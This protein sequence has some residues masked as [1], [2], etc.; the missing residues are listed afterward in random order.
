MPRK[1]SIPSASAP[2]ECPYCEAPAATERLLALHL[3]LQHYERLDEAERDAY[4]AAYRE[5]Q[6][7][8]RRFRLG[9]LGGLVLLYFGLLIVY[10]LII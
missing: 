2:E 6:A 1:Y 9:A 10:A 3:G 8:I 5:E 7:S 4:E